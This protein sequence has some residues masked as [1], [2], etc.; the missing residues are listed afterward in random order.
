MVLEQLLTPSNPLLWIGIIGI[1]AG[2]GAVLARPFSTYLRFVYP[3]AKFEAIGNPF[4]QEKNLDSLLQNTTVLQTIE[5]INANKDYHL[6]DASVQDL[7]HQL[8]EHFFETIAMMRK[9]SSTKLSSFYTAYL[10]KYDIHLIKDELQHLILKQK[11][12]EELPKKALLPETKH[13]LRDLQTS[14]P[15]QVTSLLQKHGF[16]DSLRKLTKE[17]H[18]DPLLLNIHIDKSILDRLQTTTVPYKCEPAKQQF[19][20][21]LRDIRNIKNLLRG[22]Q[23]NYEQ[24]TLTALF[25]GEGNEIATW[26]YN[27]LTEVDSV[28]HIISGLEGTSYY[29]PLKNTIELY[30]Q[31]DSVQY[32]ETALDRYSLSLIRDISQHH[33]VTFGPTLRF[34]LSKE[35]EIQNLKISIKAIAEH[36]PSKR[37]QRLLITPEAVT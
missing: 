21:M 22:K 9:D 17:D 20:G 37:I 11:S 2:A 3:N 10:F 27:E 1:L 18:P 19:I 14:E 26:K 16:S 30:H 13:L 7:H 12:K 4:I 29:E 28:P 24:D 23:L 31:E 5:S 15:E 34:L 8:D 25:I 32:F 6:K 33:Y 36:L 35:Y